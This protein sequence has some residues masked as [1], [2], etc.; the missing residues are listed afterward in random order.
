MAAQLNELWQ[1][2]INI[3]KGELTEVSFNTWIKS[4]TPISIDKDSIRL[5]VPNQF[6]KEI[7]ENRYKDLIINSMKIITTK[8]YDIAFLISSEEAL[9]TDEDQETD[10]NNV[11]TDTSSSMLNPKYKFD[12][13][14]IGNSNRF[15][16]AACLAVAEAPAKAY[17]PL[18]IYGGVG[19]GKTHLMQAIGH[20]ILDNNPKAKVVYVSSE[21]FTNELIN[22]IKDD[23]NVE[24]RNKYRNVDVLLIDDVQFIAGKERTQE[25]FFH[26]FNAL[27]ENNKQI[28]L[29][30]DRPPKEIPTLEDRL[31]SRFEW[32][33]IADIQA[34]D[35]ETRIAILKKKADVEHLNIPNDVM[36]Y[37]ATQIKSNIREL[38]GALIRIVAFSSLTNKEIS[39]D[40]A[41]EA[42]KDIISSKQNKQITIDL[43][44]D[45]VSSYFNLRIEDFKSARRTKNIAFPRQIAMYLSRKLTDMS[46]PKIGEAFG[47]RDHTTVIHAYEKISSALK[48]DD[49]L[50]YTINEITKRFSPK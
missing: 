35:F 20:Y 17:N 27:H 26:T 5:S 10:T 19:L 6:T 15:A 11:N 21:K 48:E 33:L 40:L 41:S 43:I 36:V 42:L 9:E 37:I 1:K 7:L 3:I 32:G 38:E 22:S 29:S 18:F 34:P 28:I 4:I 46:L 12:S 45:V 25:E 50:K 47:G 16:H 24:F 49:D 44:Q 14:V 2:T 30:S 13:F 31:R 39:V 23:K 8:K